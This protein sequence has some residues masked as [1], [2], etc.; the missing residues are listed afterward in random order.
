MA[1]GVQN[2]IFGLDI[3]MHKSQ[4]VDEVDGLEDL[5]DVEARPGLGE[6]LVTVDVI[7]EVTAGAVIQEH[8]QIFL[9]REGR[10]H[11]DHVLGARAEG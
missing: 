4:L 6:A 3:A 7:E 9:V 5:G 8:E 1:I 11:G 2:E 10:M